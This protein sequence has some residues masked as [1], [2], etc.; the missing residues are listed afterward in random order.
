MKITNNTK[1]LEI[2]H[3]FSK[4]YP[5][6][7]LEFYNKE[8]RDHEGSP[9]TAQIDNNQVLKNVAKNFEEGELNITDKM[10]VGELEKTFQTKYGLHAQVFRRSASLWLQTSA[11]DDW[12]IEKQNR[13]GIHST[14][15]LKN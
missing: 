7:K 5:G 15:H 8:H 2:Q 1:L 10:T 6:L 14:A 3:A 13:K 11:T 12:T 9:I 4:E